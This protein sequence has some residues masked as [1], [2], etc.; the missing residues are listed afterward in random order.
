MRFL[1]LLSFVLMAPFATP[2]SGQTVAGHP[3]VR[4][5]VTVV[6]TWLDAQRAYENIPGISAALVHDQELIWAGATGLA[7]PDTGAP[8][9]PQTAY[10]ICSISKLFTSIGVMQLRDEGRL[11]LDDRVADLLPWFDIREAYEGA[12]P[13]T[14]RGVLTHSAGLP[15]ESDFPYWIDPFDFPTREQLIERLGEQ[16]ML[17]PADRYYQ[18]SNLGLTLAGEIVAEVSG[19]P[20]GEYVRSHILDPVGMIAT[21]PEIADYPHPER[22]AAGYSATRRDGTRKRMPPFAVEGIAAA[23]GFASTVEDLARFASW[24]F[25]VLEMG[26]DEVLAANT[27]REMQRVHWL[28]PDWQTTRGL[29]FGVYRSDGV[30]YV[31]HYGLCPGYYS[32]LRMHVPSQLAAIVMMNAIALSPAALSQEAIQIVGP[33][34]EQAIEDGRAAQEGTLP[35]DYEPALLPREFERFIGSYDENPW[36]GEAAVV[37]WEAGLAIL[38]LPTM[39]PVDGLTP[40]QHVDGNRFRRIRDDGELGET[41]EFVEDDDGQVVGMLYHSNTYPRLDIE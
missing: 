29:G 36:G 23:A 31:G 33:A 24:Q 10:S 16:E 4:E 3:R 5:A 22:L 18:Y 25:R 35:S 26:G 28:D 12:P 17:Y 6:E 41:Y 8:A 30:T 15:R 13:V 14:V 7:D 11:R 19:T 27:L 32:A 20:Y 21:W 2:L 37:A 9:T 40:L 38:W 34:V 39:S 1:A